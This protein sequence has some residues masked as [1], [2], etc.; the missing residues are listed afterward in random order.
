M[1]LSLLI[2]NPISVAHATNAL[3]QPEALKANVSLFTD[4]QR[5]RFG[6]DESGE[7]VGGVQVQDQRIGLRTEMGITTGLS[8]FLA[9]S[10]STNNAISY[11]DPRTMGWNPNEDEGSLQNGLP[12]EGGVDAITTSGLRGV[13]MGVRGT[14]FSQL[15]GAKAD[16]LIEGA[17]RTADKNQLYSENDAGGMALRLDNTFSTSRGVTHP[18]IRAT[19]TNEKAYLATPSGGS[20]IEIDPAN[21][22]DMIAG[23]EFDSWADPSRGRSLRLEGRIFFGYTSPATIPS[24][25][26]LPNVITGTE[27]TAISTAE[28]S[29]FGTG[30]AVHYR[31]MREMEINAEID[32]AW[33]TPHRLEHA[34]PVT[35]SLGSSLLSA[36]LEDTYFYR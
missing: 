34:Y 6:L 7:I 10:G 21:S 32:L 30:F 31:P 35:T 25:F 18:Y 26:L 17:L 29:R 28:Y 19:Y 4:F 2:L 3:D 22:I 36:G 16:W 27:N 15:R 13:W 23:A 8:A 33:P 11:V 5:A 14:P 12:I 20:E 1:L 9:F 24:G